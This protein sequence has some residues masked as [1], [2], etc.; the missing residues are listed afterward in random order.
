MI[1]E[2]LRT[3]LPAQRAIKNRANGLLILENPKARASGN[4]ISTVGRYSAENRLRMI[5]RR[6]KINIH[7]EDT[8]KIILHRREPPRAAASAD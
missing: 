1:I 6:I 3:V 7:T 8:T 4:I 2:M 5:K